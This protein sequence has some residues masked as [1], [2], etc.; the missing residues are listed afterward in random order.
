M[1]QLTKLRLCGF[2]N[3]LQI[4]PNNLDKLSALTSLQ[5]LHLRFNHSGNWSRLVRELD[6]D[7]KQVFNTKALQHFQIVSSRCVP[8]VVAESVLSGSD[9]SDKGA[10]DHSDS[11]PSSAS[12]E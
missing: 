6:G 7:L 9:S 2:S 11:S 4:T 10:M 5:Y 3:D 1:T 12:D 8:E